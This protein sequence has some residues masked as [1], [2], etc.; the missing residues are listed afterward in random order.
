MDLNTVLQLA[1]GIG[2]FLYGIKLMSGSLQSLA[3]DRLRY[4]IETL[5]RTPLRGVFVGV[6]VSTLLQSSTAATVMT[7]SFVNAALMNLKQAIGV[8]FGANIGTTVTAQIVA[9]RIGEYAL[10]IVAM[11]ALLLLFGRTKRQRYLGD[12]IL[13][14][15]FLFLGMQ[16]MGSAMRFFIH[17]QEVLLG[18]GQQP[19]LCI[20][21]GTLVTMVVQSSTA[22]VG[23]TIAMASE[24]F[25]GIDAAIP[26]ILGNNIGT[27]FTV[28]LASLGG[29]RSAKQ[30]AAAHV[31]FNVIGVII[32]FPFLTYYRELIVLSSPYIARQLAN[33][34]SG[35]SIINVIIFLPFTPLF[36]RF[37]QY[38]IPVRHDEKGLRISYLDKNLI[39]ASPAAAVRAV[40]NEFLHMGDIVLEMAG[41]VRRYYEGENT[42]RVTNKFAESEKAVNSINRAISSYASEIWQKGLSSEVSTVLGC[43]VNAAGDLER[44]GDHLENLIELNVE[45]TFSDKA[46]AEVW[47]MYDTAEKALVYALDSIRHEDAVKADIVIKELEEQIDAQEKQY[48]KNHI[49]RLNS[50]ECNPERGVIFIDVLNNLER[51]GDHSHNIAYFTRDIVSLSK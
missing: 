27:T 23:L 17:Y 31:L 18:L 8:I 50:G 43:Y 10:S 51:I 6:L 36:A 28:V 48:R 2:I 34:H 14:F 13:G 32:F 4:L 11:G 22:T 3:G 29:N 9:F 42:E 38:I 47:A 24:G 37:I 41:L 7:V 40:K 30:A 44:V 49:E 15:G 33:A 16:T 5:T 12:G 26:L 20:L 35:F 45:G 25:I 19:L 1:G 46:A 39:Y 21:I